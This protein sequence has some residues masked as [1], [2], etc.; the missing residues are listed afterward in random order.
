MYDPRVWVLGS[1]IAILAVDFA[2]VSLLLPREFGFRLLFLR[3]GCALGA[4]PLCT[5]WPHSI[6]DLWLVAM[7]IGLLGTAI[8]GV[9]AC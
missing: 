1:T 2:L 9:S 4:F 3:R 6:C 7:F 5:L 8:P